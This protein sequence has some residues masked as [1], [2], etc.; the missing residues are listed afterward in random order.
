MLQLGFQKCWVDVVMRCVRTASFA[1]LV[2]GVPIG[3]IIPSRVLRQG[4]PI[5]PYLYLFCSE[6]LSGILRRVLEEGA[7]HG[8]RV[9]HDAPPVSHLLFADDTIIFC[10]ADMAQADRVKEVLESY[11]T[12]SGQA[13]N[14]TKTSVAFSKGV[15]ADKRSRITQSLDI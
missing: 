13:I 8:Y 7:I 10:G 11:A 4:D 9:C 12:A 2:N 6:G 14:F 3:H 5:S 15:K 1:F